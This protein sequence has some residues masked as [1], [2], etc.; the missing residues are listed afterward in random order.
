MRTAVTETRWRDQEAIA[1]A[2]AAHAAPENLMTACRGW[3]AHDLVAHTIAGGAEIARLIQLHL[4]GEPSGP[5]ISFEDREPAFRALPYRDLLELI[6]VDGIFDLLQA[7]VDADTDALLD[8]TGWAMDVDTLALHVR[9][10]LAIHRWDLTG[11]D[12]TS[13]ELLSQPDLTAHAVRA[14]SNFDGIAE[15]G[16]TRTRSLAAEGN[17]AM[18]ARLRVDGEP[19]VVIVASA[20]STDLR[21]AE[22][23]QVPAVT[24]DSAGR[25][26]MLWGRQPPAIHQSTTDLGHE[27]LSTIQR[28]LFDHP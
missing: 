28:W 20:E 7:M 6:T 15:R 4:D 3:T 27:A 2:E 1:F 8:F 16:E 17:A 24:T 25:L 21:L 18:E 11:S 19:D 10:E 9:S 14:L 22:P 13:V 23:D 26:L 5:T 12:P